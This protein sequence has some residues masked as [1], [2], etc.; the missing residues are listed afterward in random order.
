VR[1]LRIVALV[2]LSLTLLGAKADPKEARS[3]KA[4]ENAAEGGDDEKTVGKALD[5]L[6]D[7][8]EGEHVAD[9][10]LLAGRAAFTLERWPMAR[11]QLEGYLK[12]GGREDVDGI[13]HRVAICLSREGNKAAAVPALRNAARRDADPDRGA[14]AARELIQL[15]FFDGEWKQALEAQELL[16]ERDRFEVPGDLDR[17]REAIKEMGDDALEIMEERLSGTP[18]GGVLAILILDEAD[19]LLETADT[20]PARRRFARQYHD[21]PLLDQVPG[22]ADWAAEPED[23]DPNRIGVLLPTTG[24]YGHPGTLALRGVEQA[25]ALAEALGLPELELVIK[26]TAADPE[27]AEAALR[28]L[29]TEDKVVAV[30]GPIISAE[31]EVLNAVADELGVPL[32]MM[33]QRPGLAEGHSAAFNTWVTAEE[34]VDALVE[35]AVTRLGIQNFAIAYPGKES[36]A[37]LADRFWARVEAAGARVSAVESYDPAQTDFRETGRRLKATHYK[38][39]PPGEADIALAFLPERKKPQIADP[40]LEL[41]PGVDFQAIFVPDNYKRVTMLA[42]GFLFEEINLGSH[43]PAEDFPPVTLMGGSALNHPELVSRGGKYING[44]MLVDGLFLDS[45]DPVVQKFRN[46]YRAA[47]DGD[48][49][50]LEAT[51]YDATRF[52]MQILGEGVVTRRELLERLEMAAPAESV[53]GALGFTSA[54]EMRH[55]MRVLQVDRKK[56]AI[57]QVWPPDGPPD[58][59]SKEEAPRDKASKDEA[60]EA[61]A[62]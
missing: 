41:T 36:G 21:H 4:V 18:V 15:H 54:G 6:E 2:A 25:F 31:G 46:D 26:D 12:A 29:V 34:Q 53:T 60:K 58:E 57:V 62:P 37:R 38:S 44:T 59:A 8:P 27:Q 19:Q 20:E 5:Y 23:T 56:E 43:L 1:V 33:V 14:D 28:A 50:L 47:H 52:L 13:Q 39:F 35:Q 55:E 32:I 17:T 7:F 51:A 61:A 49:S 40:L 10:R 30:I 11:R 42:P 3:F 9:V 22:A 48:P 16:L 45:P 24:R